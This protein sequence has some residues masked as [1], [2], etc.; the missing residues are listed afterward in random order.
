MW[1]HLYA[2]QSLSVSIQIPLLC[3]GIQ[4]PDYP[5]YMLESFLTHHK[6]LHISCPVYNFSEALW[7]F[8]I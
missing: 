2:L 8:D 4:C 5:K 6:L 1:L 7:E 3:C